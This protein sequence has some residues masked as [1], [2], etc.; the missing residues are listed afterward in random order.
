[1]KVDYPKQT[2][3]DSVNEICQEL[4]LLQPRLFLDNQPIK[5]SDGTIVGHHYCN[6]SP[7]PIAPN[8]EKERFFRLGLYLENLQASLSNLIQYRDTASWGAKVTKTI[9]FL[10]ATI[11]ALFPFIAALSFGVALRYA[12]ARQLDNQL[13]KFDDTAINRLHRQAETYFKRE[14]KQI[15]TDQWLTTPN[16]SVMGLTPAEAVRYQPYRRPL[17]DSIL[18]RP[19]RLSAAQEQTRRSARI[20]AKKKKGARPPLRSNG[21]GPRLQR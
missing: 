12:R 21:Q 14:G 10:Q 7:Q 4:N 8:P 20:K 1:S 13:D 2:E 17:F 19:N 16:Q 15:D 3:W 9:F 18:P 6:T 5:R 11:T